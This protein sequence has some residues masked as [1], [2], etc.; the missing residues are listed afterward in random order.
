MAEDRVLINETNRRFWQTGYKPG[1]RL[2][3]SDPTDRRMAQVWL[4]IYHDLER[5]RQHVLNTARSQQRGPYVLALGLD[6]RVISKTYPNRDALQEEFSY[7]VGQAQQGNFN[8]VAVFDFARSPQKALF[9]H[10]VP[11]AVQP[12]AI[13]GW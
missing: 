13:A 6:D 2:D 7:A 3:M 11:T 5:F 12:A 9:D 1:Q 10:F 8:Y 4:S